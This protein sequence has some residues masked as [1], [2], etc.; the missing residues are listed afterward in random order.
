MA[1]F[2]SCPLTSDLCYSDLLERLLSEGEFW[3]REAL[4][5]LARMGAVPLR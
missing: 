5:K 1:E 2:S 3:A 4:E